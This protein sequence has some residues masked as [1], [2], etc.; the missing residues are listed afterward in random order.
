[1]KESNECVS[2][3]KLT[4][5]ACCLTHANIFGGVL[6]VRSQVKRPIVEAG[7]DW[8]IHDWKVRASSLSFHLTSVTEYSGIFAEQIFYE[9]V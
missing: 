8:F 4:C 6:I 7:A 1:M 5:A 9:N 2:C 3:A